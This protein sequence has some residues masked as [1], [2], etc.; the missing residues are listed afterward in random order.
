MTGPVIGP[1]RPVT[2]T[3]SVQSGHRSTV[4]RRPRSSSSDY[5]SPNSSWTNESSSSRSRHRTR[6]SSSSDSNRY[7]S[8]SQPIQIAT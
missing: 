3:G 5:S 8:T 7:I 4:R 2:F 1:V 6:S